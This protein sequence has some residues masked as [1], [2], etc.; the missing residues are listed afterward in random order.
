MSPIHVIK[1]AVLDSSGLAM[2]FGFQMEQPV[3][4]VRPTKAVVC[5][6]IVWMCLA[7][8]VGSDRKQDAVDSGCCQACAG[9]M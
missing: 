4:E 8:L 1:C 5:W 6:L 3:E 7:A 9:L 2:Q